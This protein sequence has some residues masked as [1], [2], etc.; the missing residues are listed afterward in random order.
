MVDI[1]N[2]FCTVKGL[3]TGTFL[4]FGLFFVSVTIGS[5]QENLYLTGYIK[6]FDKPQG[7]LSIYITTPGCEGLRQF[8]YPQDAIDDLEPSLI[9]KK[10]DFFINSPV[11]EKGRIYHMMFK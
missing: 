5:A 11:C 2:Y 10:I 6:S 8:L 1:K 3:L 4:C 9:G 7:V